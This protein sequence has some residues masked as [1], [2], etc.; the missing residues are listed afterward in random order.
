[1]G[2]FGVPGD[3]RARKP[4]ERGG[5]NRQTDER[6]R[7]AAMITRDG[8]G[9]ARECV[10]ENIHVRENRTKSGG[11]DGDA[12]VDSVDRLDEERFAK[13]PLQMSAPAMP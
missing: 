4:C 5:E 7:E 2:A 6:M 1:M 10:D 9:V 13:N 3:E 12:A 11:E 8:Q